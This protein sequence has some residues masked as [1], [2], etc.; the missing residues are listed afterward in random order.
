MHAHIKKCKNCGEYTL[1]AL[2]PRCSAP[3]CSPH[4]FR[5][6]PEDRF[7]KYRRALK[8]IDEQK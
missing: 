1:K 5:F 3:T 2:C 7:G 4:P 6:S 8:K